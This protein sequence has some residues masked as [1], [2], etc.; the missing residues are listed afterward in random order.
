[1]RAAVFV[2]GESGVALW[3]SSRALAGNLRYDRLRGIAIERQR[4]I[5]MTES[6]ENLILEHVRALRASVSTL[7]SKIDTLTSRVGSLEEHVAG[8]RR[9]L[10]LLHGDIAATNQR[11]DR[12]EQ[13]LDRIEKRLELVS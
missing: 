10:A 4:L 13:R 8:L 2:V 3:G 1:L 12:H 6:V 9:D 7:E 11:L 5:G